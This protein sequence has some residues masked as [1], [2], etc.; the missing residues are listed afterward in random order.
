MYKRQVD[1]GP[2]IVERP[3]NA[4]PKV[5]PGFKVEEFLTGLDNPRLIRTAPNGDIFVAESRPGRVRVLRAA[6]GAAHPDINQI[7]VSGLDRPFGIAFYPPGPDP[8]Y[9]YICNTGSV[10]RFPYRSGIL[11][12][13]GTP[14]TVG[15]RHS[16]WGV[17]PRRRTL[18]SRYR[19]FTRREEDVHL[20]RLAFQ[21]LRESE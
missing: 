12:A 2:H 3:A 5:P 15:F 1:N 16:R 11:E 20:G 10:I 21:C 14:E 6:D 19:L 9:I 4:W 18:D 17:A 13:R 7:F 8:K